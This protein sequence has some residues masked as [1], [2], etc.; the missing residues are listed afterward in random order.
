MKQF[1]KHLWFVFHVLSF[2]TVLHSLG[3]PTGV[4]LILLL[5]KS[6][7]QRWKPNKI[8]LKQYEGINI[9]SLTVLY[10]LLTLHSGKKKA[11]S[12]THYSLVHSK[13]NTCKA[14]TH[15]LLPCLAYVSCWLSK[16]FRP[17]P[18]AGH[19]WQLLAPR[20]Q[21]QIALNHVELW[22]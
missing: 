10:S 7:S 11:K 1:C 15:F 8:F 12:V 5:G 3:R 20:P 9:L 22:C 18:W 2:L 4:C 13:A 17:V 16:A 19:R 21:N 6:S 14:I